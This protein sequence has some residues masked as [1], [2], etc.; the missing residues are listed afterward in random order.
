[1]YGFKLGQFEIFLSQ[2]EFLTSDLY[3]YLNYDKIF[4]CLCILSELSS[5]SEMSK[6]TTI[7]EAIKVW[8]EK[9]QKVAADA[10]VVKLFMQQP[11]IVK[12]EAGLSVLAKC[13]HLSL[14]TNQIDRMSNFQGLGCLRIL[15]LSRNNIKKIEG[16][17]AVAD[18]LEEL[19]LSYNLIEKLNGVE[20]CKKLKILYV[21]NNKIKA[22]D[23]MTSLV[24]NC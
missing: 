20:M 2:G 10:T 12:I 7:K 14:G 19:W 17:D 23:G 24:I 22:W 11:F 6:S 15:S 3:R 18:T 13:E 5:K 16:L 1:M 9:H 8:E 21:S 4:E